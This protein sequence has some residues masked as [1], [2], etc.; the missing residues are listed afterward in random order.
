[1]DILTFSDVAAHFEVSLATISRWAKE[2]KLVEG[3]KAG[4]FKTVTKK[5]VDILSTDK[6]F[7]IGHASLK[8]KQATLHRISGEKDS[9]L[10]NLKKKMEVIE[11]TVVELSENLSEVRKVAQ[12][13]MNEIR[14]LQKD[15]A[16]L[17]NKKSSEKKKIRSSKSSS[18]ATRK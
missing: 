9:E 14:K 12:N 4:K 16:N 3:P 2:G 7:Q 15:R 10:E 17:E 18:K 8:K 1:M 5:S 6:A 11:N 13:C